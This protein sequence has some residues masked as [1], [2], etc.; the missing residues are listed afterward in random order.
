MPDNVLLQYFY[1]SLD[2]VNKGVADQLIRGG[3]MRQSFAV[4]SALLDEMIKINWTWHT[5]EDH[6][7]PLNIGLTKEQMIKNQ[8]RD[9]NMAKM[10][11]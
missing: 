1:R 2:T 5:R 3:I 6:V 4:A 7:S 9:E 10:M 8:E 11:N